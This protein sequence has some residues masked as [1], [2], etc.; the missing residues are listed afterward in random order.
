MKRHEWDVREQNLTT[1][2]QDKIFRHFNGTTY[3]P[4]S[5]DVQIGALWDS[6]DYEPGQTFPAVRDLFSNPEG[7]SFIETNV[8]TPRKLD[9][10]E[11]FSIDRVTF[12]FS[13]DTTDKILYEFA[14][15]AVWELW[16]GRKCYLRAVIVSLQTIK[17]PNAPIRICSFCSG[18]YAASLECP[19]CGARDFYLPDGESV[20][21][22]QFTL[23]VPQ[24]IVIGNQVSFW[25]TFR[26]RQFTLTGKLKMWC[27]LHGL[28]ARGVQ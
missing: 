15:Q 21:G 4:N 5:M 19:G 28:H 10:P 27:H 6:I 12:T 25:C 9:A 14:E 1:D 2:Q 18:V 7:K 24:H 8:F 22:L 17:A 26:C 13:H 20:P 11:A 23:D 16:L 3:T